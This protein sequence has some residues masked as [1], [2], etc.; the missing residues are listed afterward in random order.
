[1]ADWL[2]EYERFWTGTIDSFVE[3]AEALHDKEASDD[4]DT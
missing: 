1:M 2:A 4:R 3:F